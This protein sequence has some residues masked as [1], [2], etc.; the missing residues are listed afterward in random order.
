MRSSATVTVRALIMLACVVGIPAVAVWGTSWPEVL[1]KFQDFRLPA[2][3]N[4]AVASS[5]TAAG[6]ATRFEPPSPAVLPS[7]AAS[8]AEKIAGPADGSIERLPTA[9]DPAQPSDDRLQALGVK[10]Q[11][12]GATYYVLESWGNQQHLFRFYCKVA[13]AGSA[14]CTRCFEAVRSE[15]LQ[16]MLQVLQ[17]V[18]AWKQRP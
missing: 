10:L 14:N 2:M 13:V 5:T 15:P 16:A 11:Q 4:P 18:E 17:Q 12:L 7:G 8:P 1:K 6:G 9:A 3:I